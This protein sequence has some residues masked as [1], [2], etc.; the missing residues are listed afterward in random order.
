LQV[1][2]ADHTNGRTYATALRPPVIC[3]RLRVRRHV[4]WLNGAF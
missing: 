3:R 1:D 2:K 4:L